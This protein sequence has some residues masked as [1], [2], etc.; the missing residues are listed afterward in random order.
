MIRH[1]V[2]VKF[3]DTAPVE[4]LFAELRDIK[5]K[6]PGLLAT[7]SGMS[8]SPEKLERGHMHGFVVDF[9]NWDALQTYQDHPAHKALGAKL[10]DNAIGGIDGILVFDYAL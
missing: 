9:E 10:V 3:K 2:L 5:D 6:V 4:A 8:E 1:I 7:S